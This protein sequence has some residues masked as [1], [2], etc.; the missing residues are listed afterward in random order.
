MSQLIIQ[1]NA[2]QSIFGIIKDVARYKDLL[3]ILA[4]R[5]YK[6]R[7]AQTF[8]G[9]LWAFLQPIT[10]LIIFT[11]I[12]SRVAKLDTGNIPYAIFAQTGMITWV[13]F[14]FLIG[15]AGSSIAAAQGMIKKIYFPR[16]IIPLSKAVVGLIDFGISL[17]LFFLLCL[18]FQFSPSGNVIFL[19]IF[20]L[21]VVVGGLGIGIWT[22]ALTVR[23]R[24]FRQVIPFVV[25]L[26]MYV[27]P[28]A[29]S[30]Q[31][32]PEKYAFLYTLNPM[33]GVIEGVRWCLIGGSNPGFEVLYSAVILLFIFV[34][35][36]YYFKRVENV[37]ADIL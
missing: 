23:Y 27:S 34:T 14:S 19:P 8:L 26:G 5:D 31:Q 2:K 4:W 9:F 12:F 16:L 3:W 10:T 7:Y 22:S 32:V 15:Q 36:L 35:S 20:L 21:L 11:F 33:V 28:I 1:S 17:L 24:D 18:Y 25:Q 6:V 29:Y 13:Y 30:L 37:M